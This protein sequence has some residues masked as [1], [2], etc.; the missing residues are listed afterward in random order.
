MYEHAEETIDDDAFRELQI[1]S[2]DPEVHVER[3]RAVESLGATIVVLMNISG[4]D[5]LAAIDVYAQ[6]VLPALRGRGA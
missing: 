1:L 6:S 2:A 4:A 3:I 5:P